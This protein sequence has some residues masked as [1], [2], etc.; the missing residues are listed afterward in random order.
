MAQRARRC[1]Y[2][3]GALPAGL[4][5]AARYCCR[6]HRQRAY[7]A[8]RAAD[9]DA[10]RA[11]LRKMRRSLTVYRRILD[12]IAAD[13]ACAPRVEEV[14]ARHVTELYRAQT[15]RGTGGV[16]QPQQ[17]RPTTTKR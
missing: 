12:D 8:A 10:V 14:L 6:A 5:P 3:D 11:Q 1:R 7:E 15:A 9:V 16:G 17:P 13:P 2:C 4:G